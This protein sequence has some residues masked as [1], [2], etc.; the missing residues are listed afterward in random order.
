MKSRLVRLINVLLTIIQNTAP[1]GQRKKGGGRGSGEGAGP[2]SREP[3][4]NQRQGIVGLDGI[5][6][7]QAGAS[8]GWDWGLHG[9]VT[10]LTL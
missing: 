7:R 10:E 6:K 4:L 8:G 1:P 2:Q 5:G 9:D 3:G